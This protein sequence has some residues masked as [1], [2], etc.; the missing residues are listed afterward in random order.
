[1]IGGKMYNEKDIIAQWNA[2]MYD[3]NETYTDDVELALMLMG[4]TPKEVLE[5]ACG[6]GRF[7]VPMAKAGHDVTGL[8]FDEYMLEKIAHKIKNEKTK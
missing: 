8:D 4:T 2:D 1:M 6:S 3:L 5:I 7:L